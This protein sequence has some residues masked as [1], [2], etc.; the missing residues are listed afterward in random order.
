MQAHLPLPHQ[1]SGQGPTARSSPVAAARSVRAIRASVQRHAAVLLFLLAVAS[2]A[3]G[4]T[5]S[6]EDYT[7]GEC[8]SGFKACNDA[9][10]RTDIAQSGCAQSGCTPCV[11]PNAKPVCSPAG[12]CTIGV[13]NKGFS[14]CNRQTSDGCEVE[15]DYDVNNCN[16]C[17][18][19]C[20]GG[21]NWTPACS[22]GACTIGAC[23]RP[24]GN[25]NNIASDGCETNLSTDDAN[26]GFCG[27]VCEAGTHCNGDLTDPTCVP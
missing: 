25:C 7:S 19:V 8:P 14:D 9:C 21:S 27:R 12:A 15:T 13:C 18:N 5:F 11:T 26:C 20:P 24:A 6:D 2:A 23:E 22:G 3:A 4:C 1:A 10:V 16:Q 17:G